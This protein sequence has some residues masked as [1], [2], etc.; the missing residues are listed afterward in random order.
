VA[1]VNQSFVKGVLGG[2]N[3]IGRRIRRGPRDEVRDVGPWLEIVGVVEDLGMGI[4][5]SD[6]AA[7]LYLPLSLENTP[8]LRVAVGVTGRPESFAARLRTVARDVE[9]SLQIHELMPLEDVVAGQARATEYLSRI[10]IGLSALALVLSL[11]AIYS[12]TEFAVS[13]RIREIG[14][15]VALGAD[16]GRVIGPILRRPLAQVGLG[17]VVGAVLTAVA[18]TGIFENTPSIGEVAVIAVYALLMMALCLLACVVPVRRALN[19]APAEV[20]RGD[21]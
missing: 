20:L 2:Q 1:I 11:T 21:A 6:E 19:V 9:P 13:R 4:G 5:T 12:V 8:S 3:P 7:G 14:I 17:I 10:M 18:S 15:R 16:R